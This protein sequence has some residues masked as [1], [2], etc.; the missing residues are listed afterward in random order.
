MNELL[1]IAKAFDFMRKN[2]NSSNWFS[3]LDTSLV[4]YW[5]N[6]NSVLNSYKIGDE[7]DINNIEDKNRIETVIFGEIKDYSN[8][9]IRQRLDFWSLLG[10]FQKVGKRGMKY[11][12]INNEY[13]YNELARIF[14]SNGIKNTR[15]IP[16]SEIVAQCRM[17]PG[18]VVYLFYTL[19]NDKEK[20]FVFDNVS[21]DTIIELENKTKI[22]SSNGKRTIEN[23]TYKK[24]VEAFIPNFN[25]KQLIELCEVI[26]SGGIYSIDD[27]VLTKDN[28][29]DLI[30]NLTA[31]II[32]TKDQK[33]ERLRTKSVNQI[34]GEYA[35]Y[36]FADR[37]SSTTSDLYIENNN[38]YEIM[39]CEAAHIISKSEIV[40]KCL[41]IKDDNKLSEFLSFTLSSIN[42]IYI[43]YNYHKLF[44]DHYIELIDENGLFKFKIK[45]EF[46]DK[47]D[48][49][50]NV[51]GFNENNYFNQEK[52]NKIRNLFNSYK[53]W[54]DKV[55]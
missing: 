46:V 21:K 35:R 48:S 26:L 33:D 32:T 11:Q 55:N 24:F 13:D 23:D 12:L 30:N 1:V 54:N 25:R 4:V 3:S 29:Q 38:Q 41:M 9:P 36:K 14:F 44:D 43:P 42:G 34:I 16:S 31:K 49:L 18:L 17:F 20:Q 8:A 10:Y 6:L 50:I 19:L 28:E 15:I 7:I 53:E 2:I 51:Y 40:D 5:N 52:S 45:D 27:V 22:K 37:V 39:I 47:A